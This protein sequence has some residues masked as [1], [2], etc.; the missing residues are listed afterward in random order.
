MDARTMAL[1]R[2]DYGRI[3]VKVKSVSCIPAYTTSRMGKTMFK[4]LATVMEVLS[5][6][7][8]DNSWLSRKKL[9]RKELIGPKNRACLGEDMQFFSNPLFNQNSNSKPGNDRVEKSLEGTKCKVNQ[10]IVD[11]GGYCCEKTSGRSRGKKGNNKGKSKWGAY[12]DKEELIKA[13]THLELEEKEVSDIANEGVA[14]EVENL[15]LSSRR[16]LIGGWV[17]IGI[18]VCQNRDGW[19]WRAFIVE[20]VG[21]QENLLAS[22]PVSETPDLPKRNLLMLGT[23]SPYR[24]W[25]PSCPII[26]C[27]AQSVEPIVELSHI[28]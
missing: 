22:Y 3:L 7:N 18:G 12:K 4:I 15:L 14:R 21:D 17:V 10:S 11:N 2:L 8:L 26:I 9:L 27:I 19:K 6:L 23:L 1:L 28:S 13:V 24:R 25:E 16:C 5:T 20:D